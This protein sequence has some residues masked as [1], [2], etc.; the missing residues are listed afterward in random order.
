MLLPYL[1]EQNLAALYDFNDPWEDSHEST[2]IVSTV[3]SAFVCPSVNLE[4]PVLDP[5][6][7]AAIQY[8]D[9]STAG[10]LGFGRTDYVFCK[11]ITD[12]WCV[13]P[14]LVP[15]TERGLFDLN[16]AVPLRRM[17]DGTSNTIAVGEGAGGPKW[18]LSIP[19]LDP[20]SRS[21][22][23]G[24]SRTA[25]QAWAAGEPREDGFGDAKPAVAAIAACTLEPLN[26][27]PVTPGVVNTSNSTVCDK[28]L[29]AAIGIENGTTGG[30]FHL[31]PN[32]RSDHPGGGNFLFADGS[33]HFLPESINMLVYQQLSTMAGNEIAV[34]PD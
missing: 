10:S 30:G 18:A 31:T 13:T 12:A 28:S 24:Q 6:I 3:I 33:V 23:N 22:P 8:Y 1:E 16:W 27:S 25:Y 20:T 5:V 17:T 29:P 32:F 11:G 34:I 2:R 9:Q 15:A 14:Q 19:N 21:T 7:D 26:K 4:N